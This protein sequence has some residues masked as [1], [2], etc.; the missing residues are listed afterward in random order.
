MRVRVDAARLRD[1]LRGLA[2]AARGPRQVYLVGGA[3]AVAEGWRESTIDIDLA[4]GPDA[5]DVLRAIPAIEESLNV[6][7]ELASPASAAPA[8]PGS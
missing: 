4:L 1:V 5:D 8:V 6:I 2:K 7:V 3:T